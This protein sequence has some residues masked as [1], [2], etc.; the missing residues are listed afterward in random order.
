M[1][2]VLSCEIIIGCILIVN[3]DNE[4][5]YYALAGHAYMF[6][7]IFL[8]LHARVVSFLF[9]ANNDFIN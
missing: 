8:C 9:V 1:G 2:N 4:L 3:C 7:L 6:V 5:D